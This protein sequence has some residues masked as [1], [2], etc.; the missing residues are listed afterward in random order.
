VVWEGGANER[1]R[2]NHVL[3]KTTNTQLSLAALTDTRNC[4][5]HALDG[6]ANSLD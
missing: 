4:D 1:P 3:E 5:V 6:E 2:A